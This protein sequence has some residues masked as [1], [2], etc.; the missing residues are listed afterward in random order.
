[1]CLASRTLKR[2][3]YYKI[4][5]EIACQ[6]APHSVIFHFTFAEGR[7]PSISTKGI[8]PGGGGSLSAVATREEKSVK[9]K[10]KKG[11]NV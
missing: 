5:A 9:G 7:E 11:E 8:S 6:H 1:M 2:N 10:E 4:L 3:S